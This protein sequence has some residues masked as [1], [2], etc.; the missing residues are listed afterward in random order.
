M[1]KAAVKPPNTHTQIPITHNYNLNTVGKGALYLLVLA[2]HSTVPLIATVLFMRITFCYIL[3]KHIFCTLSCFENR[4]DLELESFHNY[5]P[6]QLFK[7]FHTSCF[8]WPFLEI[9]LYVFWCT[10]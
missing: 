2:Q 5:C 8:Y 9:Y 7:V 6:Q 1:L 4:M 10:D 3:L